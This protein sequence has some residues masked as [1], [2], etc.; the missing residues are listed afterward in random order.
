M[1]GN[2]KKVKEREMM[3]FWIIV[4]VFGWS[5]RHCGEING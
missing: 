1:L 3:N 2:F 4:E 5:A